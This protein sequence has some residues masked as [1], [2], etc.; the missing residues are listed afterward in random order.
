MSSLRNLVIFSIIIGTLC[1]TFLLKD[2]YALPL[3]MFILTFM[4]L[5]EKKDFNFRYLSGSIILISTL[6]L[7]LFSLFSKYIY[8]QYSGF[9]QGIWIFSV[10][11]LVDFTIY[12]LI[13]NRKEL[14][15]KYLF[16]NTPSKHSKILDKS[17]LDAPLL[18]SY[19]LFCIVDSLALGENFL[20]NLDKIGF[21]EDFSKQF[22]HIQ[23]IFDYY[24]VIKYSILSL[25]TLMFIAIFIK[26]RA[27]NG[28]TKT[29]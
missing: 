9:S 21:S 8:G 3:F 15:I 26:K 28:T 24:E 25:V 22:W 18:G 12:Y 13:S 10:H 20:R 4:F 14:S 5:M 19:F 29:A 1:A 6:E 2:G 23:F 11:L 16:K 27:F 7:F 17:I